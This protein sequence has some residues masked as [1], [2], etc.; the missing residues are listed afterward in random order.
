[1]NDPLVSIIVPVYNAA[2]DLARCIESVRKQSYEN[3]ELLLVN[4]GSSD[5]SGPI[6]RMYERVDRRIRVL[7]KENEGVSAARNDA[8]DRA[9]GA[10]I[11]FL[12]SDDY[13][14]ENA[15]RDLVDRALADDCD[16][17]V[18]HYYRVKGDAITKH[19][20]L[21]D[22][23]VM[24]QLAFARQL[25]EE[26]ASFYYGVLWNKL[27]RAELLQE[28]HVRCHEEINWSEDF[29]FNLEYIR[30]ARRF[31]ALETPVYYYVKNRGSITNSQIDLIS[32]V[33]TKATLFPYYKHL[34]EQ[35]G[36]Y[37][38]YKTQIYKY[39]IATASRG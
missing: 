24:D 6:C 5:T 10:F 12:D 27:Y 11:Q 38:K 28:N 4:D 8:L 15:T 19:G 30:Y 23:G 14:P 3:W 33:K 34:Y 26:P 32:V 20:F 31:A 37:E 29:L 25:M 13:L 1:M 17:V 2:P 16:L 22:T 21:R 18:A 9:K 39:L 35:L 36:L 7:E